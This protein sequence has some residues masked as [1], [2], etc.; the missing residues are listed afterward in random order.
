MFDKIEKSIKDIL[1]EKPK[2]VL[3][4]SGGPDSVFLFHFLQKL[5]QENKIELIAAHLDHGWRKESA[6]D[7]KFCQDLCKAHNVQLF[8]T[9]ANDLSL[10]LKFD[11]SQEELGRKLRRHFFEKISKEQNANFIALA[12]HLQDQQETFFWR[13]IRGTSLT[14]LSCMKTVNDLYLRPLLN[15]NKSEILD[16]LKTNKI[17]YLEDIT[18]LSENYLRNRIRKYVLPAM[19]KSDDRFDQKFASTLKHLQEENDFLKRL[20][21]IFFDQIFCKT[22]NG[23]I[24][25][26]RKIFNTIDI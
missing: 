22:K 10:D 5:A 3:G 15:I 24:V 11:G 14:G 13:I 17:K 21:A 9:H 23:K 26:N 4:L 6:Q 16:F 7:V 19:Q 2:I 18:N 1:K 25:G 20:T 8:A 12:H